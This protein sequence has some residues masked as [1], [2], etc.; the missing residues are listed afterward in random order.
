MVPIQRAVAS[1]LKEGAF[2]LQCQYAAAEATEQQSQEEG[3][4]LGIHGGGGEHQKVV[5]S[6]PEG[7]P[8]PSVEAE[9][10][11]AGGNHPAGENFDDGGQSQY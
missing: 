8:Q 10:A 5:P 2:Q 1:F 6:V 9:V 4:P 7:I 3:L 11:P